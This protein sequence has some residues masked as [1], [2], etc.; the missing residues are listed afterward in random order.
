M[1]FL[2]TLRSLHLSAG[3]FSKNCP[4]YIYLQVVS[5]QTALITFIYR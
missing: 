4:H 5:Q 3:S 1:L 2:S